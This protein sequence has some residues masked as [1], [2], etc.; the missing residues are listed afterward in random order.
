[1]AGPTRA[2]RVLTTI[3]T[4]AGRPLGGDEGVQMGSRD[5]EVKKAM[6]CWMATRDALASAERDGAQLVIAHE[7][8]F[9][10]YDA[11]L[12]EGETQGWEA[13][14]TNRRRRE[15]IERA[16]LTLARV[17]GTADELCVFDT[18]AS[19]LDLGEPVLG[20]KCY[21][22]YEIMPVPLGALV[23]RVKAAVGLQHVRVSCADGDLARPVHR[24]GLPWGG[25]GLF[26]NISYQQWAMQNGCDVLIAGESDS[27]GFRF[28]AECHVPMIETSHEASEIPGLRRFT[29]ILAEKHPEVTWHFYDNGTAWRWM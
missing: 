10:P 15:I 2:S 20:Q 23:E 4:L 5:S 22:I 28:S 16:G 18:F 7:S 26:V 19:L 14:P 12:E 8:L 29:A 24:V 6:V 25:L 27:Y 21:K 9:Y 11:R 13:W 3:E 1:M 17:H